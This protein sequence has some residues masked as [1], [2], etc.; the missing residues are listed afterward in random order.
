MVMSKGHNNRPPAWLGG[1]WNMKD[2]TLQ[3]LTF[4][5]KV[6]AYISQRTSQTRLTVKD[7]ENPVPTRENK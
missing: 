4:V 2:N 5:Y 7:N 6:I 3:S 1:Y